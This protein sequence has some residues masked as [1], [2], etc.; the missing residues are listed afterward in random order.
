VALGPALELAVIHF[1][2][3]LARLRVLERDKKRKILFTIENRK[4][5][6]LEKIL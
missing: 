3:P 1:E 6:H 2:I 4:N 5:L